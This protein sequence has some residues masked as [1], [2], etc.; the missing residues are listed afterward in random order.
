M[1]KIMYVFIAILAVI[2]LAVVVLFGMQYLS[3]LSKSDEEIRQS[4]LQITPIG[5]NMD[6]VVKVIE[7]KK[8]WKTT[9]VSYEHGVS[10]GDLGYPDKPED[11]ALN[12]E[13]I[14][15]KKSIRVLIGE[16]NNPA[17]VYVTAFWGFDKD[18]KLIDVYVTKS[19]GF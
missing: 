2:V 4:V 6:S 7:S 12:R 8:E 13:T 11:I 15:G 10:Y 14:V 19:G 5:T 9:Y 16:Y 18:S 1:R 3:P 17:L